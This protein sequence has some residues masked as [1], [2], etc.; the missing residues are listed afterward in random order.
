MYE[1]LVVQRCSWKLLLHVPFS[2]IQIF[3]VHNMGG[4]VQRLT[5]LVSLQFEKHENELSTPDNFLKRKGKKK[6]LLSLTMANF[7]ILCLEP[8]HRYACDTITWGKEKS[9]WP[10]YRN[11]CKKLWSCMT[12]ISIW[13]WY[14]QINFANFLTCVLY[15]HMY[16]EFGNLYRMFLVDFHLPNWSL[17]SENLLQ[18]I[19]IRTCFM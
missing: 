3:K 10:P 11:T 1:H 13:A 5:Y 8:V 4:V 18:P 17:W 19:A 9:D 16:I 2:S 15:L 14:K 7:T 12:W 6:K